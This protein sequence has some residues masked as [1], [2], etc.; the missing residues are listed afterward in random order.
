MKGDYGHKNG[1]SV[2]MHGYIGMLLTVKNNLS[3][4]ILVSVLDSCQRCL[5]T[6]WND[7]LVIAKI[8]LARNV[9]SLYSCLIPVPFPR[10]VMRAT[11]M[12]LSNGRSP[13]LRTHCGPSTPQTDGSHGGKSVGVK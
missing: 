9:G 2:V 10:S 12:L 7:Q 5:D 13:L 1:G 8:L 3:E 6:F 11:Y 4:L